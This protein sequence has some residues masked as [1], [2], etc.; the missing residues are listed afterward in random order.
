MSDLETYSLPNFDWETIFWKPYFDWETILLKTILWLRNHII[1]NHFLIEKPSYWKPFY[2][3][4]TIFWETIWETTLWK[5]RSENQDLE[6]K[7]WKPASVLVPSKLQA[8]VAKATLPTKPLLLSSLHIIHPL[9]RLQVDSTTLRF[10]DLLTNLHC[11][12][13]L[14]APIYEIM[15]WLPIFAF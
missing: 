6:T 15:I 5:P 11:R 8:I 9:L 4:E 13:C 1:G 2:D 7:I 10:V 12:W 3:W 14:F